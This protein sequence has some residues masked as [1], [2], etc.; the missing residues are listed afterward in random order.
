M[1]AIVAFVQPFAAERVVKTLHAMEGLSGATVSSARGFGRGRAHPATASAAD[2]VLGTL[3]RVR[4]EVM[5]PDR[6]ADTVVATICRVARTGRKGDGKV[7][8]WP[9]ERAVRISTGEEGEAAV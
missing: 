4:V 3:A 9:L 1:K 6:L 5:V 7:Y 2:E 8:V